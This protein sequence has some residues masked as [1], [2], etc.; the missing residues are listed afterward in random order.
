P[1]ASADDPA[2]LPGPPQPTATPPQPPAPT[3][4]APPPLRRSLPQARPSPARPRATHQPRPGRRPRAQDRI[5]G[6]RLGA[7]RLGLGLVHGVQLEDGQ[8]T[9]KESQKGLGGAYALEGQKNPASRAEGGWRS[10]RDGARYGFR[11]ERQAR[12]RAGGRSPCDG[13]SGLDGPESRL[14]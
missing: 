1:A 12:D 4:P 6:A 8:K 2:P 14:D 5:C 3:A 10:A 7:R 11:D 13:D 9:S